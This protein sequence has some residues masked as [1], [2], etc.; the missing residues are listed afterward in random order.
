MQNPKKSQTRIGKIGKIV[1][2]TIAGVGILSM[3]IAAPNALQ[4]LNIIPGMK[5]KRYHKYY[6][7][8]VI[9]RLSRQGFIKF[10]DKNGKKFIKLTEKGKLE[11]IQYKFR[12]KIIKKPKKW[13]K[14][15]RVIIFDIKEYRKGTR[16]KLRRT[17]VNLGFIRLQNSVWIFP[18]ECEDIIV[19]LKADFKIGKDV[20]YMTV[21]KIE[22]DKWLKKEF[23]LN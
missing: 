9:A 6:I 8:N 16:D 15:W 12:D 22:N 21:D 7:D 23:S 17:L 3:A 20:L 18:Y 2:L 13:D 5:K 10:E 11:V 1:L 4:A 14:K 19:M